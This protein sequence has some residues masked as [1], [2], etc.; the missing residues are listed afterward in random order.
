MRSRVFPLVLI[1]VG[2]VFLLSKLGVIPAELVRET[3]STGW[4][5]ILIAVGVA[6]LLGRGSC[7]RGPHRRCRNQAPETETR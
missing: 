1:G 3:L 5:L 6:G 7:P 2:S 4:P